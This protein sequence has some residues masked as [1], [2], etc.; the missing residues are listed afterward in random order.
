MGKIDRRKATKEDYEK[1]G[2]KS[3]GRI[4]IV[5]ADGKHV[6]NV[7]T[8][9]QVELEIV[10]ASSHC[11]ADANDKSKYTSN[12]IMFELGINGDVDTAIHRTRLSYYDAKKDL[13]LDKELTP[14]QAGE[15]ISKDWTLLEMD[16]PK[17]G[18]PW[19]EVWHY[20]DFEELK[21]L[22]LKVAGYS[23]A[24][25]DGNHITIQENC[26]FRDTIEKNVY[27][28]DCDTS[29]TDSGAPL[30]TCDPKGKCIIHA[31]N[32]GPKMHIPADSTFAETSNKTGHKYYKDPD[33]EDTVH[34]RVN[35][36]VGVGAFYPAFKKIASW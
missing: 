32:Q 19:M 20:E 33:G 12:I 28:H 7:C 13:G 4:L 6:A 9:V 21:K 23:P 30:Y 27:T 3:I 8:A 26:R 24:F 31:I 18:V 5:T 11:L 16:N 17:F 2:L 29:G 1:N 34:H 25:S 15:S 35:R 10:L 36:A 14:Y 22:K